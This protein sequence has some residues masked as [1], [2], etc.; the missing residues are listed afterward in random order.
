ML[1]GRTT[2][3]WWSPLEASVRRHGFF[4]ILAM[5][6]E[7]Q[8]SVAVDARL[9]LRQDDGGEPCFQPLRSRTGQISSVPKP[10]VSATAPQPR[11]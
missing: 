1:R 9:V 5:A 4:A 3:R 11:G 6:D 7:G 2:P 10:A 8:G